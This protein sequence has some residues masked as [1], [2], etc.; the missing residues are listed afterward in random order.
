MDGRSAKLMSVQKEAMALAQAGRHCFLFVCQI[1]LKKRGI[2]IME[3]ELHVSKLARRYPASGIRRMAALAA[4]YTDTVNLTLGEPDFD[5]PAYIR[6][7]AKKALDGGFTHYA[8]NAGRPELREGIAQRC[9]R[10]WDGYTADHVIVTVGALEAMTLAFMT[11]L[12]PGDEVLVPD[13]CFSNY[14]GQATIVGA[15]AVPVPTYGE[16]G[17]RIQAVDIEKAITPRT[18]G[19][20]LNSPANPTG[21]VLTKEDILSIAEVV[22]KYDLWVFSDDPYDALVFDGTECFSIAQVPEVR[23]KVILLN[24]FSK[25]YAMTGWRIGYA[26]MSDPAYLT[27]MAQLQE[28]VVSC[29]PTFIQ[30][31]AAEAL[32]RT[33]SVRDMAGEYARRRDIL[34]GGLNRIPGFRCGQVSGGFY[35]FPNIRAFGKSSQDFAEE[36]LEKARVVVIPGTAFGAMG[37]GYLRFVF[38][39]SEE[40]LREA[41]RRIDGYVRSAYPELCGGAR[42]RGQFRDMPSAV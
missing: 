15:S 42:D 30:L 21:A 33:D 26:V 11:L 25:T 27:R 13:P 32:K 17:F 24:S 4:R 22:Q 37:E 39:N 7:A 10:I 1:I 36:L 29:V 19:L 2:P 9:R 12:D 31:A 20:V 5:T 18:R 14:Y 8:S 3:S 40:N 16:N 38:A 34:V 6:E 28:G 41:L 23:S 35:A